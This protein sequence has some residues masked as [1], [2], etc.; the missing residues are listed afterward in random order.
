MPALHPTWPLIRSD[1]LQLRRLAL[2][3]ARY[4][5]SWWLRYSPAWF[6]YAFAALLPQQ[7]RRL[8]ANFEQ[9]GVDS[10]LAGWRTFAEYAR[11]LAE[12]L[13]LAAGR[14]VDLKLEVHGGNHLR[15]A[16][17][18]GRGVIV[19]TAHVGPW[20]AAAPMLARDH[21]VKV[22]VV[23]RREPN[24]AAREFHDRLRAQAGV[25]VLHVD[26]HPLDALRLRSALGPGRAIA[27]QL[28][29]FGARSGLI[30]ALPSGPFRLA[31][32]CGAPIVSVFAARRDL[33]DYEL[34]VSA[35]LLLP[36]RPTAAELAAAEASVLAELNRWLRSH[37]TQWFDFAL[38]G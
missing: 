2:L 13:A 37:P 29:R 30:Q 23:M 19:V 25:E 34:S 24:Q 36:K 31:A 3:G 33:F 9:L 17:A 16:L 35:P 14:D 4:G 22:S 20:D 26:S 18:L 1:S 38:E 21:E 7:R 15:D 27:F 32:L 12:G 10:R 8:H 5:P 11:C 6:G 28:D